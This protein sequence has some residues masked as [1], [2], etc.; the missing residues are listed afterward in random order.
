MG[1][2]SASTTEARGNDTVR[3]KQRLWNSADISSTAKATRLLFTEN[4]T[5]N[6]RIFHKSNSS[7]Y[8]KDLIHNYL[9]AGRGAAV[10]PNQ[11]GTK[12]AAHYTLDLRAR[13]TA[14]IRLRPLDPSS[15]DGQTFRRRLR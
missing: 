10:N 13:Q 1:E 9:V 7:P 3:P 12:A 5:N 2:A 14:V 15:D 6:E 4:E 11:T 8:V